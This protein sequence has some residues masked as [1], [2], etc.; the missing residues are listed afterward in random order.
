MSA[1]PTVFTGLIDVAHMDRVDFAAA[2]GDGIELVVLKVSTG[3]HCPDPAFARRIVEARA[4]GLMVCGYEF[5]TDQHPG[6]EQWADFRARWDAGC[7]SVGLDPRRVPV[8]LDYER[9]AVGAKTLMAAQQA[10][11][12]LAAARAD[13]YR[14]G[15]YGGLSNLSHVFTSASDVVGSYDLWL[16]AYGP[17]PHHLRLNAPAPWRAKGPLWVQYSDGA[18]GPTDRATFPRDVAGCGRPDRSCYFG[19]ADELR[20]WWSGA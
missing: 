20:A 9:N 15:L 11:D 6:A 12:Y 4:Q 3:V 8:W 1:A 18:F 17:S 2:H 10:R 14:C 16:A 13:G 5:G 7:A 19:G